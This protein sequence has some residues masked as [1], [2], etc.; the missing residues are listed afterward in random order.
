MGRLSREPVTL[1][2]EPG[3]PTGDPMTVMTPSPP[4]RSC[5]EQVTAGM[6]DLITAELYTAWAVSL[7]NCP[8]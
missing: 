8:R 2:G 4:V 6:R 5:T 7:R 3:P 1:L